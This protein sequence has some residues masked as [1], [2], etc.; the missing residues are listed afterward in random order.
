VVPDVDA[1]TRRLL[2]QAGEADWD[3][4]PADDDVRMRV[5]EAMRSAATELP[6][7]QSREN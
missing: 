2:D 5:V 3:H 7:N 1:V 4:R 6:S